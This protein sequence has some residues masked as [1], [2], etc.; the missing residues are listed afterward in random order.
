MTH[1][2][3]KAFVA[4]L[5]FCAGNAWAVESFFAPSELK[6]A[7]EI[8]VTSPKD[9]GKNGASGASENRSR[10]RSQQTD[11]AAPGATTIIILPDGEDDGIL[12]PRGGTSL[13]ENRARARD[14]QRDGASSPQILIV[15]EQR[16]PAATETTRDRLEENRSKARAYMKNDGSPGLVGPDALPLV[17]CRDVDSVSG[18]IGD[19]TQ[20]GSIIT[21]F[22]DGRQQKVR[23]K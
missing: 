20:S 2:G 18:R 1:L 11:G 6:L 3:K 15:P 23:C 14:Y 12:A 16:D 5:A 17:S 10:A 22:K 13:P 8:I 19:D 9:G 7:G 4:T 21:I